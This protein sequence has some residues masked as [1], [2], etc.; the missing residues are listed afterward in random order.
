MRSCRLIHETHTEVVEDLDAGLAEARARDALLWIQLDHPDVAAFSDVAVTLGLHPLAVEDAVQARDRPKLDR[1]EDHQ[2]VSLM[3]LRSA[4]ATAPLEIG[5]VMVFVGDAFVVTVRQEHGD[6]LERARQRLQRLSAKQ[7]SAM[8]V[9]HAVS[10]VV[11]DDLSTISSR[12]E[13]SLLASAERLFG[14]APSDEAHALYQVTRRLL[15]M[16]HAVQPL[17]EPLRHLSTGATGG[18]DGEAA[19]RFQDV[20]DHVLVVDREVRAHSELLA[21]LRGSN[22]S[23]IELQQNTD[24][25]KIA[26]WAAVIA[27]PT[28]ITGFY[29]MNVPYPGFGATGGL[30]MAVVMQVSLAITVFV[31]LRRRGWL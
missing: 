22:D 27:V 16:A 7:P 29:G 1:Y 5:R 15:S 23:R 26:A 11:V 19:R 17:I 30:V 8:D 10:A 14:D 18:V 21:H 20:L 31:V 24:M 28:A 13:G 9:L 25:R 6:T 4:D 12:V 2:F 3:T